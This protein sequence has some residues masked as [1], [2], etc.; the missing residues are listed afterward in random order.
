[1]DMTEVMDHKHVAARSI[2]VPGHEDGPEPAP[3][4][5]V[6]VSPHPPA[7]YPRPARLISTPCPPHVPTR[8]RASQLSRTPAV[9][10]AR[11]RPAPQVGEHSAAVLA[12]YGFSA[13]EIAALTAPPSSGGSG[14]A[15]GKGKS[16]L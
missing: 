11:V 7:S 16:K 14:K 9:S 13:D 2:L 3:A 10:Q 4:P 8:V 12:E 6:R 5:R 15:K 1:M